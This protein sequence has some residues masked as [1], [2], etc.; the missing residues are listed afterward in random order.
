MLNKDFS[1]SNL[2]YINKNRFKLLGVTLFLILGLIIALIFG[3][4]GNFEMKGYNEFN[5]TVGTMEKSDRKDALK[6]IEKIVNSYDASYDSYSIIGDG[7]STEVVIRYTKNISQEKQIKINEEI[8]TE[9]GIEQSMVTE[10]TH[11][12]ASV[13]AEDYIFCATAILIILL[14]ASIFAMIRYNVPSAIALVATSAVGNLGFMSFAS[15]LR[16]S[17]GLSYFAMLVALNVLM[18]YFAFNVFETIRKESW[19]KGNDYAMAIKSS[20]KHNRARFNFIAIAIAVVGLLF[21]II[22]TP[23]IKYISINIMFMA[24]SVLA[25]SCYILPFFWNMLI[26]YKKS[27]NS[28]KKNK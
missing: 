12:G 17:V 28:I 14:V 5:V 21:V 16:L 13:R 4:N 7:G 18:I 19:L 11:V 20:M 9:L 15:I 27:K 1:K 23:T 26:A 24:V 6:D 22:G 8:C 2:D 10:H 3:F 25:A